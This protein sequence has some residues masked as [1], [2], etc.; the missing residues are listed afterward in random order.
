VAGV[1]ESIERA[2]D[3]FAPGGVVVALDDAAAGAALGDYA[4][5]GVGVQVGVGLRDAADGFGL[6]EQ[7]VAEIDV[8]GALAAAFQIQVLAGSV[9]RWSRAGRTL[10]A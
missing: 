5:E 1:A 7:G 10:W 6:R 8:A 9:D 4:A 3:R 2:A